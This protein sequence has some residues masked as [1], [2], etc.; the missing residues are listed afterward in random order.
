M[1]FVKCVPNSCCQCII[2]L[3]SFCICL[4]MC[5]LGAK[6]PEPRP[7]SCGQCCSEPECGT[8]EAVR[9]C[10]CI[11]AD[12]AVHFDCMQCCHYILDCVA[13]V[14]ILSFLILF[15]RT[16]KVPKQLLA[17]LSVLSHVQSCRL[18]FSSPRADRNSHYM[19]IQVTSIDCSNNRGTLILAAVTLCYCR[20]G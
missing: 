5:S 7:S 15:L 10:F 20:P 11:E 14:S 19:Q 13:F 2:L 1:N 3:L 17:N 16:A 4:M 18:Q 8:T 6:I 9:L 12:R